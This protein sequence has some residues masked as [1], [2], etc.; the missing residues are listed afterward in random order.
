MID[1]ISDFLSGI[2]MTAVAG[3]FLIASLVVLLT[4][5]D[6]PL[7]PAWATVVI[8]GSPL[9]YLA[10]T[11]LI[12]QKRISSALLVSIATIACIL[13]DELFAAGEIVFI[14]AIGE[15]LEDMTVAR[16]RKGLSNL[17]SLTPQKGRRIR[18]TENGIAEE[19]V[20]S[21]EIHR[22]DILRVLPGE[23]IPVDGVIVDGSTSLDQSIMTGES[24]PVDKTIG[25][26]VF[27]GT[28]NCFGS[29]DIMATQIGEDS[30]LQKMIRMVKESEDKKAPTQRTVDKWATWLVPL[31]LLIAV[32]TY[33]ITKDFVRA[34]TVLV[35]F[36]PCALV[37]ATPTSI[38]A[39]I[40][41]A[42]KHGILIKSGEA[43]EKMGKVDCIAFD[44][45]GTLTF[46]DLE[47]CDI[48]TFSRISERDLISMASSAESH[49]EHPLGKTI[50]RYARENSIE[51]E[52]VSDFQMIPGK[53]ISATLNGERILCGNAVYMHE[54]E[55]V[56][57]SE[58]ESA[59]IRIQEQGKVSILVSRNTECCGI[60]ALCDTTRPTAEKT[61]EEL[62]RAGI[63]TVLL[64]GDNERTAGYLAKQ[65]GIENVRAGLL[66]DQKVS[67]VMELQKN[68]KTV[69]MIGDGI[70]DAPALKMAD[71]GIAMGSIGSDITIEAADI[72]FLNDRIENVPYLKRLSNATLTTIKGC[73]FIS[74]IINIV[75]IIL[76]V[77]GYLNPI[78]G[79]L[80]HNIGSVS[81]VTCAAMLYDRKFDRPNRLVDE[82]DAEPLLYTA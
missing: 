71:V 5:I 38:M 59:L 60:V 64:T 63:E 74:V 31:A 47:V 65:I 39:A 20:S 66:P 45:T 36:C 10:V 73:I 62:T 48:I 4:G 27:C 1:R 34:V 18:E 14:M 17:I 37:L 53:G 11:E 70:N 7:D 49:S 55:I 25:D 81:V 16:A 19:I 23:T 43:L 67:N 32:F 29:V 22:N 46:G 42:T 2:K 13:I 76:S 15:I 6:V 26:C 50:L 28:T 57:D 9:L 24:V 8:S 68:G 78:T 61:I 41:Q 30:S 3:M 54:K 58:I 33:L 51:T 72:A 56:M 77:L 75:A 44:K 79:A 35:V 69:C 12:F 80:V 40:G 21:E 82:P 52:D